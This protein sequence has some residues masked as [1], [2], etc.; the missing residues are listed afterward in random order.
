MDNRIHFLR[1]SKASRDRLS[2]SFSEYNI[3]SARSPFSASRES[4][5]PPTTLERIGPREILS[6]CL[7]VPTHGSS[8]ALGSTR[9]ARDCV[10]AADSEQLLTARAPKHL[11]AERVLRE[12]LRGLSRRYTHTH[13]YI[14]ECAYVHTTLC[15]CIRVFLPRRAQLLYIDI[16]RRAR[17]SRD[18]EL[19]RFIH[20]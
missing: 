18:F 10:R 7:S 1:S 12:A 17:F 4:P 3:D 14:Y 13:T 11:S 2:L 19:P 5:F 15:T 9:S 8:A 20:F 16:A 6:L